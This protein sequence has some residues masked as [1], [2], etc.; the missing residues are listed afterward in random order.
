MIDLKMLSYANLKLLAKYQLTG[1]PSNYPEQEK[2]L[3]I[4]SLNF[5]LK[6]YYKDLLK[7][8]KHF[9]YRT[10][11][12]I[13]YEKE[14]YPIYEIEINKNAK[15]KL[16]ILSGTHGNEQAGLL[17][18][19]ELLSDIIANPKYYRD[20]NILILTP[21]NPV[22]AKYNSRLNGQGIDINRDFKKKKTLETKVV[23]NSMKRFKQDFTISLHEG[24]QENGTFIYCNKF[25]NEKIALKVLKNAKNCGVKLAPRN[26]FGM[27][28]N[29][30][31]YYSLTGLT[32]FFMILSSWF[33]GLETEGFYVSKQGIPNVT[34]ETP[35]R[36]K[37]KKGRINAQ[38]SIIKGLIKELSTR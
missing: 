1:Q 4:V 18:V 22:G 28:L 10:V 11:E 3:G 13:V 26:Y 27:K 7:F 14:K 38:L 34:I 20:C 15:N 5:D 25:V 24:S 32:Y 29:I 21:H 35:W 33:L 9:D 36:S 6:K 19:I 8:K 17:V 23:I 16:F 2:K 31:G 12:E 37:S 30:P